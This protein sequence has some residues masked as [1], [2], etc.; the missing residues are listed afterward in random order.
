MQKQHTADKSSSRQSS[1]LIKTSFSLYTVSKSWA[2]IENK[3]NS[4]LDRVYF[5]SVQ[6]KSKSKSKSTSNQSVWQAHLSETAFL[7]SFYLCL[8]FH[9]KAATVS[10][11]LAKWV[12]DS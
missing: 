4:W 5:E 7:N 3:K 10:E 2:V 8:S 11:V 12:T 6:T 1:I 9:S